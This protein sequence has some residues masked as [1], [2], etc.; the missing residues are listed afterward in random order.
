[1]HELISELYYIYPKRCKKTRHVFQGTGMSKTIADGVWPVM[2]TPYTEDNE[3]DY[4][5]VE[6]ILEW[7]AKENVAGVFAVCQSS[8]MHNLSRDERL[9]LAKFV[10]DHAPKGMGVVASGHVAESVEEQ[11]EDAKKV[12]DFGA[13]SFVFISNMFAAED[14]S[15]DVAKK[16]IDRLITEIPAESFGIYEC[17]RPYKRLISPELLK[18]CADT[19]RFSFLKDT[20][21]S[22]PLLK[23]KAEAVKGTNLKI[24]NAN[25]AT[26]LESLKMGISGYSGVMANFHASEYVWLCKNF[27]K[28]PEKAAAVQD[29]LG[30]ASVIE[31]QLYPVNS[32]YHMQLEGVDINLFSR[33]QDFTALTGS[34]QMEVQQ[35][36][37]TVNLFREHLA[38]MN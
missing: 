20:C 17:P 9:K 18:W 8:E 34:R 6:A 23:A 19:G 13:D 11:I 21:C 7:Y 31:N 15:E 29:L 22:L 37:R 16:A 32:K 14:E 28:E 27:K 10:I 38:I 2:I 36:R 35:M 5:G 1:M 30:L 4:K 12:I 26:L 24:Y 25:A 3:I 33:V